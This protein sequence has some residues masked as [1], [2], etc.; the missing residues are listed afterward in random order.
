[1]VLGESDADTWLLGEMGMI[2]FFFVFFVIGK[3]EMVI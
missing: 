2:L 3:Y 1:M